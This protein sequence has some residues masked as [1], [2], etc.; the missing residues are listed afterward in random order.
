MIPLALTKYPPTIL[1]PQKRILRV[2]VPTIGDGDEGNGKANENFIYERSED[3]SM[4]VWLYSALSV[5]YNN[6]ELKFN[7]PKLKLYNRLLLHLLAQ[8]FQLRN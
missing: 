4:V 5:Y 1:I 3:G 8:I 6:C 2:H 7:L